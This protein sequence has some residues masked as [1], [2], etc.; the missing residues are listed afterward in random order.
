MCRNP[1]V[2]SYTEPQYT[3]VAMAHREADGEGR[4]GGISMS[5]DFFGTFWVKPK[6]TDK[7]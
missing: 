3:R 4:A 2:S 5:L 7:Y 1:F 6:S